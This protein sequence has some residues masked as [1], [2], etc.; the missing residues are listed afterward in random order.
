MFPDDLALAYSATLALARAGA[1]DQAE[2]RYASADL[3]RRAR[4]APAVL[5]T[6]IL[7]LEARLKKDRAWRAPQRER[8]RAF[9]VASR[10]YEAVFE[11]TG[12]S[13]P[14]VNAA[15]LAFLSK[16]TAR[17]R[18]LAQASAAALERE[19]A[20][21]EVSYFDL[22]TRAEVAILLLQYDVAKEALTQIA[23]MRLGDPAARSTTRK[24]L[25]SLC[26]AA[27][28]DEAL[29]QSIAAELVIHYTGHIFH[30]TT[31]EME[32]AAKIRRSFSAHE[33][34]YAYGSL[35]A[36]SDIL[37]A[38]ALLE[39]GAVLHV[40]LPFE[41]NEFRNLSVTHYGD[42]WGP[43]F[44]SVISRAAAVH[45]AT[46]DAFLGDE[47]LFHYTSRFAMGLALLQAQMLDGD[48]AQFV[49]RDDNDK[50]SGT[51]GLDMAAW[52][53]TGKPCIEIHLERTVN[54]P[55]RQGPQPVGAL[56]RENRA[57]LFGDVHGFSKLREHQLPVFVKL[58]L[59][60]FATVLDRFSAFIEYRNT[61]GDGLYLV[62]SDAVASAECA[63][64]LQDTMGSLDFER[65]GLPL[66][67]GL[68]IG[69]HFGPVYAMDD[70]VLMRKGFMGAHVS[71]TA[72][73]E[74]V[75]PEGSVYVTEALAAEM[76]LRVDSRFCCE[77]VGEIEA[78]KGYGRFRM[79][80]LVPQEPAD[81]SC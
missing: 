40:V 71:R 21:R 7:A 78:A 45:Y 66:D 23:R 44:D 59:G 19:T 32:L 1:T 74:P 47:V 60:G 34:G 13:F 4:D 38:E 54:R 20:G 25:R 63:I 29:L 41:L 10:A 65:A 17:A 53:K 49:L 56:A 67:M 37:C 26:R 43:R 73:I 35:A 68:R 28:I 42:S 18:T 52:V 50:S 48:A 33:V 24:Q 64:A 6:D 80:S 76:V 57:L 15:T 81:A 69:V 39:R 30:D 62:L 8:Q 75:T 5:K 51:V 27:G 72:R 12:L 9:H 61:W 22:A 36:G 70:P 31:D 77:Y 16:D 14:G 2:R 46:E 11:E 3:R 58:V 79:Y 55:T